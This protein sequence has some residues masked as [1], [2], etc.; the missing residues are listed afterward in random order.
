MAGTKHYFHFTMSR[1]GMDSIIEPGNWGRLLRRYQHKSTLPNGQMFGFNWTLTREL[2]FEIERMKNAPEAPSR[3]DAAFVLPTRE[4][5]ERY[6]A[7]NDPHG[8]QSLHLVTLV[9]DQKPQHT[10]CLSLTDWPAQ[11]EFLEPMTAMARD[12]WLGKGDGD[13]EVL[14]LSPLRVVLCMD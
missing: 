10:G 6:R 3:F 8:T 9:D 5:A 13:K 12:Y 2:V 7:R 4:E 14:T 1:L 11:A